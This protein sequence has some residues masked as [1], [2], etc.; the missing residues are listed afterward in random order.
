MELKERITAA[1]RQVKY[2]GFDKDIVTLGAV[3]SVEASQ[4][5]SS[6]VSLK[7]IG[8]S[9]EESRAK[10]V[11][12]IQKALEPIVD[13]AGVEIFIG[14]QP[15][16]A[17][18]HD[19]GHGQAQQQP[20]YTRD[21]I[22][23]VKNIIPVTSGKGGVGKSTVAVNLAYTLSKLGKKVGVLDLDIFGPS[24][25]KM[26]GSKDRLG[27]RGDQIIPAEVQ[28]MKVISI[29]MAV[30]D[31]EA[32]IMRGPMVMKV[33]EQL[34]NHV[35]WDKL[36]YLIVDMPPGTGDVPLSLV[37]KLEITGAVVVT[38]PQDVALI[39]VR[40][41]V[42]MYRQTE[43]HILGIVE[44]MSHYVCAKCGDTAHIFGKGGGAREAERLGLPLLGSI[45]LM[46][47][48]CEEA[49]KGSPIFDRDKN[50]ELAR[51]FEDL[52]NTVMEKAAQAPK[53]PSPEKKAH[54]H[55]HDHG[56]S[57][58]HHHGHDHG[59]GHTGHHS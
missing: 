22:S 33:Q 42:N 25:P 46:K 18:G 58:D 36:D 9:K 24:I 37:Q 23:G 56:H 30:D 38:T 16:Q 54:G 50:P 15:A 48:I 59:H 41:A 55:G 32:M 20:L 21:R 27:T 14:G 51:V 44:N 3:D 52:A 19:H 29:G 26:L 5:G 28:G 1:L 39:D 4:D 53:M 47:V 2:P 8:G 6:R 10:L 31:D 17:H 43:T 12:D 40:R 34:M 45:P 35:D 57:H 7:Q 49:D 13:G 11:Q